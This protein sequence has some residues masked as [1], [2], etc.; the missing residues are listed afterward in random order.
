MKLETLSKYKKRMVLY[1]LGYF[2][3]GYAVTL[4]LYLVS[5]PGYICNRHV[6]ELIVNLAMRGDFWLQVLVWPLVLITHLIGGS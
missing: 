2:V 6:G 4:G 3:I 5:S 1:T